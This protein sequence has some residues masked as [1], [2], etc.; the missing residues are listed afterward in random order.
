MLTVTIETRQS[1]GSKKH[2]KYKPT[3]CGPLPINDG[4]TAFEVVGGGDFTLVLDA[5]LD[6]IVI[7]GP[8]DPLGVEAVASDHPCEVP[9]AVSGLTVS[10]AGITVGTLYLDWD[11]N[12]DAAL[13][14]YNVYV[15]VDAGAFT[16][17]NASLLTDSAF[18]DYG[19]PNGVEHCYFVKAV[20]PV[21]EADAPATECGTPIGP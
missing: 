15:S 6:P 4:A 21:G 10:N 3:S 18:T 14:G 13:L 20:N 19:L 5:N 11:D 2:P 1:P 17:V 9:K 8:S 7:V 12:G 16:L